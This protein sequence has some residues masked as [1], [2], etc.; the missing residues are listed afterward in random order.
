MYRGANKLCILPISLPPWQMNNWKNQPVLLYLM[1]GDEETG[2]FAWTL[3]SCAFQAQ[4]R[5]NVVLPSKAM[6]S[7]DRL[8]LWAVQLNFLASH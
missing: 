1:A 3:I 2:I 8:F 6:T 5:Y 7:H 4:I